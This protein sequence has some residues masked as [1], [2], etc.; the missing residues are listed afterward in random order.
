MCNT[1]CKKLTVCVS[2]CCLAIG[3]S[4]HPIPSL[5]VIERVQAGGGRQSTREQNCRHVCT[6][7]CLIAMHVYIYIYGTFQK[8]YL[9]HIFSIRYRLSNCF[10]IS[11]LKRVAVRANLRFGSMSWRYPNPTWHPW[12]L[13]RCLRFLPTP[14]ILPHPKKTHPNLLQGSCAVDG[15]SSRSSS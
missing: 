3:T 14:T 12:V 9:R 4:F 15:K 8:G 10:L 5:V 7:M 6:C 2:L 1:I 11:H 13:W